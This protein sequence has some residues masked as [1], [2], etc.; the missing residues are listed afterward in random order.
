VPEN[1]FWPFLLVCLSQGALA[2]AVVILGV[3]CFRLCQAGRL[4]AEVIE[5]LHERVKNLEDTTLKIRSKDG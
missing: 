1:P 4:A 5:N 2:V 3:N